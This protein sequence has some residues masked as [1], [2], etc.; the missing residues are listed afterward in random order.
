MR[1]SFVNWGLLSGPSRVESFCHWRCRLLA[2]SSVPLRYKST[3]MHVIST[4]AAERVAAAWEKAH[5]LVRNIQVDQQQPYVCMEN[6]CHCVRSVSSSSS[7]RLSS[8]FCSWGKGA[9][10][11]LP[12]DSNWNRTIEI[13]GNEKELALGCVKRRALEGIITREEVL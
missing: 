2:K 7:R 3:Y 5:I 11:A 4:A 12:P 1:Q 10:A 9:V 8:V 6:V 13:G